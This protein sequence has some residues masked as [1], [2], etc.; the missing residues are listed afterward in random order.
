MDLDERKL[1]ILQ[2][3]IDDYILTAAPVG[4]RTLS[5]HTDLQLSSATIRNEMSDLGWMGYLDQPH[6]SSGRI[7]SNK[8]Y[9]LYV[10]HMMRV[11]GLTQPEISAVESHFFRRIDDIQD[12]V[13]QTANIISNLTSYTSMVLA[14]QLHKITIKHIQLVPVTEGRA[15]VV[16]VTDAGLVKDAF[17]RIPESLREDDLFSFSRLLTQ[18]LGNRTVEEAKSILLEGLP[19]EM[20]QHREFLCSVTEAIG[21]NLDAEQRQVVLGG[22]QN[23]LDYPEYSD[24]QKARGFLALLESKEL[25]YQVLQKAT[26]MEFSITIGEENEVTEMKDCSIVTATYRIGDKPAGSFGVIGPTRMNYSKV[27]AVLE[28]MGRSLSEV[29]TSMQDDKP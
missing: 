10:D 13:T 15:L 27:V 26:K 19:H 2:A 12:I 23:I 22:A 3:I 5:K 4:S 1:R 20:R 14:P 17:V 8:A 25:L 16:I 6:T 24:I 9:R 7:P 11:C 28:Y 21:R 29:L 18:H